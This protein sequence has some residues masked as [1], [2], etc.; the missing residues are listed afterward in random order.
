MRTAGLILFAL[1]ALFGLSWWLSPA[2]AQ[3]GNLL[4][5]PSFE[6]D[7]SSYIPETPQELADCPRNICTTAQMPSGWKPWW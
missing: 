2:E 1:L 4:T 7:Y 5:N 3:G 6:G